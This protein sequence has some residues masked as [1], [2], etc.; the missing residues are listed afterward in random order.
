MKRLHR[1]LGVDNSV[2][3]SCRAISCLHDK[4]KGVSF[5]YLTT[6]QENK[7]CD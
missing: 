5:P 4:I 6:K 7:V 2:I 3:I 1:L